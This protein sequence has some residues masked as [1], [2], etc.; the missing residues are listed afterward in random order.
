M[1]QPI[2]VESLSKYIEQNVPE[3][4]LPI[5]VQQVFDASSPSPHLATAGFPPAYDMIGSH[6]LT[7][8]NRLVF[9]RAVES[10]ILT[11]R[12]VWY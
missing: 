9:I 1:R 6:S 5:I 8:T 10:D 12:G 2:D 11:H 3:I 7:C 4:E